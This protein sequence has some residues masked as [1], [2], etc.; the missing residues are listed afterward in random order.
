MSIMKFFMIL[1]FLVIAQAGI[2]QPIQ[3][4]TVTYIRNLPYNDHTV[5]TSM[6]TTSLVNGGTLAIN[7]RSLDFYRLNQLGYRFSVVLQ[8]ASRPNSGYGVTV[9]QLR[10][11]RVQGGWLYAD[12]P[13][14]IMYERV[15][16]NRTF[17]VT[18]FALGSPAHYLSAGY[19]TL[20]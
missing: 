16:K 13:Y 19:V 4:T 12:V 18:V 9:F 8:D 2:A 11:I 10:S 7:C 20:Q 1:V 3:P 14:D 15:L 17:Y 5:N 6:H